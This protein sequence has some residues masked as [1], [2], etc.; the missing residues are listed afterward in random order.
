MTA[1]DLAT[2]RHICSGL[3]HGVDDN[4]TGV[5]EFYLER[6]EDLLRRE[7]GRGEVVATISHEQSRVEP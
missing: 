6:L 7:D 5:V 3:R 4:A 1:A 2:L